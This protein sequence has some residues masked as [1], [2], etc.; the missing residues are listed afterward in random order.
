MSKSYLNSFF[1]A[2]GV[3]FGFC[4]RKYSFGVRNLVLLLS[5]RLARLYGLVVDLSQEGVWRRG[6]V[7]TV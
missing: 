7:A 1:R 3:P 6:E 4:C 5:K 2:G